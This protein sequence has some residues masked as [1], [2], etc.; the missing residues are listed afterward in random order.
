MTIF[1]NLNV[2]ESRPLWGLPQIFRWCVWSFG[3]QDFG[4]WL[5]RGIKEVFYIAA[6]EPDLNQ[7]WG[8]NTLSPIYN[9]II[10]LCDRGLP[11]GLHD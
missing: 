4:H 6:L 11:S 3:C 2:R 8:L 1:H 7:D 9:S 10:K 5:Q